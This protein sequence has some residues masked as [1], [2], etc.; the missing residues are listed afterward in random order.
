MADKYRELIADMLDEI[1]SERLLQAVYT[2][3]TRIW[4]QKQNG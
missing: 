2:F 4:R 1:K 3:V